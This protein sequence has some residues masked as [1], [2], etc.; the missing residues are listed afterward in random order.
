MKHSMDL[1]STT[2]GGAAC[3]H[4]AMAFD[5]TYVKADEAILL[6]LAFLHRRKRPEQGR[7]IRH[8]SPP[9]GSVSLSVTI[10]PTAALVCATASVAGNAANAAKPAMVVA[11]RESLSWVIL[12]NRDPLKDLRRFRNS[13]VLM[14]SIDLT[15][16]IGDVPLGVT[17]PKPSIRPM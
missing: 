9:P 15:L 10:P 8:G 11:I 14:H 1:T 3:G 2:G 6:H 17:S 4:Q 7:R 5:L 13:L 12:L 16:M